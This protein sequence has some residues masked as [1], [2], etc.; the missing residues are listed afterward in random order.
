MYRRED[1]R[2]AR[3]AKHSGWQTLLAALALTALLLTGCAGFEKEYVAVTDYTLPERDESAPGNLVRVSDVQQLREAIRLFVRQ[4]GGEG[5]Q[6]V[7]YS[8]GYR[9]NPAE[10]IASAIWQVRTEDALCAYCVENISYEMRQFVSS[11]EADISVTYSTGAIPV[12]EIITMAYAT[13]LNKVIEK[14]IAAGQSRIA[15]LISRSTLTEINLN[16]RVSE[17]YM[18]NPGLAPV[19]PDCTITVFSGRG[20]ER[21]FEMSFQYHMSKEQFL[22]RKAKL[23]AV[24]PVVPEDADDYIRVSAAADMLY[25]ACDSRGNRSVY[26]ALVLGRASSEG[27]ALGFTELC[28]RLGL[29]CY[30]VTGQKDRED[31]FWNVVVVD[32]M[33]YHVDLFAP[34]EEGFLKSDESFW[35]PYRWTTSAYPKC[36]KN[37]SEPDQPL[38]PEETD[39]VADEAWNTDE[40]EQTAAGAA[41]EEAAPAADTDPGSREE[42]TA[43]ETSSAAGI[44]GRTEAENSEEEAGPDAEG[45]A[46]ESPALEPVL[47][48]STDMPDSTATEEG[49]HTPEL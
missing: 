23:D 31:H 34:P 20:N 19:H 9:G 38:L 15:V 32:G 40:E 16:A 11:L 1:G 7:V 44:P 24:M 35:G 29:E 37:Y 25:D 26:A 12:E 39:T 2:R 10:D 36:E 17:L 6:R 45:S 13:E 5:R 28:H 22:R 4:G 47:S 21:L 42:E 41:A 48:P 43:A 14:T 46:F 33:A 30:V 27:I 49:E 3:E 8:S 18:R